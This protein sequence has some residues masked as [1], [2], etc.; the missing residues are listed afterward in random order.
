MAQQVYVAPVKY[1]VGK[2]IVQEKYEELVLRV[3]DW[4]AESRRS[5]E[6]AILARQLIQ[7][8]LEGK[9]KDGQP[10]FSAAMATLASRIRMKCRFDM[11]TM[12]PL[13][14]GS[15][16]TKTKKAKERE[17]TAKRRRDAGEDPNIPDEIRKGLQK[18]AKYGDN[19]NVFLSSAEEAAWQALRKAYVVQFPDLATVNADA[20][21]KLLC[22]LHIV[23]ERHRTKILQ[24]VPV[25][26]RAQSDLLA[27]ISD[28]KKAL[29]IH[30][31]QLAKRNQS[32]S[33]VSIG[34][35]AA[36]LESLGNYR[37]LRERFWVEELLQMY[38]MYMTPSADGLRYQLDEV[39][40]FGLTRS[41]PCLCPQCGH[42]VFA[43]LDI[44]EIEAWL[45]TKGAL[46]AVVEDA[47][48]TPP[49]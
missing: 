40:L 5:K 24:G 26:S 6:P 16:K 36:H 15:E 39:G 14:T 35:M 20:E 43:G 33:D 37:E 19:P 13:R 3:A 10:W 8:S 32:K 28:L 48:T 31:D 17:R 23:N 27:K 22:D 11:D 25:D 30:P 44:Q 21:L 18:E 38:Q 9:T 41:K 45:V 46:T 4:F 7:E 29:G 49:A 12:Q 34:A 47:S 2:D 42:R 1:E